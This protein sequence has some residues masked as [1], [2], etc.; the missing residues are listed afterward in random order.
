MQSL[1]EAIRGAIRKAVVDAVREAFVE[2]HRPAE[3]PPED[4][5]HY[6]AAEFAKAWKVSQRTVDRAIA[7][8]EIRVVR[9]GRRVLI[10]A[11][12]IRRILK[13]RP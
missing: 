4:R 6:T 7:R 5:E 10:P 1:T 9:V 11:Q 12:E 3:S 13:G 2:F 8:G